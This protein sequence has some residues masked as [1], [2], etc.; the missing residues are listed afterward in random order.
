MAFVSLGF[1]FR[2]L[3]RRSRVDLIAASIMGGLLVFTH[4]WTFDQ[5]F[6]AT[7][8]LAGLVWYRAR[9][10][11]DHDG[12]VKVFIVYVALIVFSENPWR[13]IWSWNAPMVAPSE[14]LLLSGLVSA[15]IGPFSPRAPFWGKRDSCL[16]RNGDRVRS[17]CED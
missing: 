2:A 9:L 6:S 1:F 11:G 3:K 7:V 12:D 14:E 8:V 17:S 16:A 10:H 15:T 5:F 13:S 4:P